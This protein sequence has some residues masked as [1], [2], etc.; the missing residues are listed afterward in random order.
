MSFSARMGF[1]PERKIQIESMDDRLQNRLYNFCIEI[2]GD[3]N[4][5]TS[6]M[7]NYIIDCLG[8]IVDDNCDINYS[9]IKR[10]LSDRSEWYHSY[11]IIEY[12]MNYYQNY[13]NSFYDDAYQFYVEDLNDI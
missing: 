9:V 10:V 7:V 1:V 5:N 3:C 6:G 13:N 12:A 11:D 2:I 4:I 8:M